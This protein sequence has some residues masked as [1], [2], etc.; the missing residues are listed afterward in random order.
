MMHIDIILNDIAERQFRDMWMEQC[1][2]AGLITAD[3][4]A[5]DIFHAFLA[6]DERANAVPVYDG[7]VI[8]FRPL[9]R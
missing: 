5:S 7:N 8:Q 3:K 6:E 1:R 9:A 2:E 4:L